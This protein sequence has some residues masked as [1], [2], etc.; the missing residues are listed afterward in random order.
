MDINN[1]PTR[2]AFTAIAAK[3]GLSIMFQRDYR[4]T[5]PMTTLKLK[6]VDVYE[7]LDAITMATGTF[8]TP[9]DRHTIFI[10]DSNTTM[11]R[12]YDLQIVDVVHLNGPQTVQ[13]LNDVLNM[14]RQTLNLTNIAANPGTNSLLFRDT[15][16]KVA[17]A[18]EIIAD[19]EAQ[20]KGTN[21]IVSHAA[22][23]ETDPM[24]N[25]YVLDGSRRNLNPAASQLAVTSAGPLSFD[26]NNQA[27]RTAIETIA[28]K[29][30]LSV[31]YDRDFRPTPA[32]LN[33]KSDDTNIFSAL[34][35]VST[36]LRSFWVPLDRRSIF[37]TDNNSTKHRDFDP[38]VLEVID[39]PGLQSPQEL[40]DLMNEIR[41]VLNAPV[42]YAI[43]RTNSLVLRDTP[44]KVALAKSVIGDLRVSGGAAQ[45]AAPPVISVLYLETDSLSSFYN[46][47]NNAGLKS[48]SAPASAQLRPR[49][50]DPFSLHI[51]E[52][53]RRVY[54][55]LGETVG[56]NV[57]FDSRFVAGQPAAFHLENVTVV[58]ALDQLGT[59]THNFWQVVDSKTV[60]ITPENALS[61]RP[62]EPTVLKTFRLSNTPP[63][64][65][66]MIVNM[67]KGMFNIQ[68]VMTDAA[69]STIDVRTRPSNMILLEKLITALDRPVPAP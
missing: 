44:S 49:L 13:E 21:K 69:S 48:Y 59:Q 50:T 36:A 3:A 68:D 45:T 53:A 17:L 37:I 47:S 52:D 12:D 38:L 6:D 35:R 22:A 61:T 25:A 56:L 42:I 1:Q 2:E 26:I 58:Q 55:I 67:A 32:T 46:A 33:L 18:E 7:A 14:L 15:P 60:Y 16:D 19:L 41:Q 34:D 65:L 64:D 27:S 57:T 63:A 20:L 5:P 10:V 43:P 4:P 31:V 29:A 30:G 40:N 8:W 23:Y 54:E 24:G 11:H 9:L 39:L 28:A 62:Y 51:N 66:N